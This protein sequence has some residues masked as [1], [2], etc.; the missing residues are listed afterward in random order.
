MEKDSSF[1]ILIEAIQRG[2]DEGYFKLHPAGLPA[3]AMILWS[4]VHGLSMLELTQLKNSD[5]DFEAM[6]EVINLNTFMGLTISPPQQN[7]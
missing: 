2:I 6:G 7:S 3:M 1:P 4:S 5:L